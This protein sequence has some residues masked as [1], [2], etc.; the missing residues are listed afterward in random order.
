MEESKFCANCGER[1]KEGIKFCP[2]CGT[3][4]RQQKEQKGDR[5]TVVQANKVSSTAVLSAMEKKPAGNTV[6]QTSDGN[7]NTMPVAE[8]GSSEPLS[9]TQKWLSFQGRMARL[10]F[11]KYEM[12]L[13]IFCCILCSTILIS[14][15]FIYIVF[16]LLL[17]FIASG[18]SLQVRRFHDLDKSGWFVLVAFVPIISIIVPIFLFFVKGTEGRNR[19]G[20]DPLA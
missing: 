4:V 2:S 11:F 18:I 13:A 16:I 20:A 8:S 15:K 19:F 12:I 9:F 7:V 14:E 17:P 6:V 10:Q 3:E 5:N 1:L